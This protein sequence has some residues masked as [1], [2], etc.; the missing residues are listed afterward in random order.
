MEQEDWE[1]VWP[2]KCPHDPDLIGQMISLVRAHADLHAVVWKSFLQSESGGVD[3]NSSLLA[4]LRAQS[5]AISEHFIDEAILRVSPELGTE[6]LG[7]FFESVL[8][9]T[10]EMGTCEAADESDDSHEQAAMKLYKGCVYEILASFTCL[11]VHAI[12]PLGTRPPASC[13][14]PTDRVGCLID[15]FTSKFS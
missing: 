3:G 10:A 5:G 2:P 11:T 4:E 12:R 15:F 9:N 1:C 7:N 6:G 8:L 14:E 13:R